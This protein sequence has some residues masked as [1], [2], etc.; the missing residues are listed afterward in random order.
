MAGKERE[1]GG[2]NMGLAHIK[3]CADMARVDVAADVSKTTVKIASGVKCPVLVVR[4]CI[5]SGFVVR[6]CILDKHKS[7]MV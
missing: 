7:S 5:I 3:L 4:G 2:E 1:R 6:G